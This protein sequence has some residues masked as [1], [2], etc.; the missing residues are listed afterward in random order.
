[1]AVCSEQ[2]NFRPKSKRLGL[3]GRCVD[4]LKWSK[5]ASCCLSYQQCE[6]TYQ[7]C[8]SRQT[9]DTVTQAVSNAIAQH[10]LLSRRAA[11]FAC[12][13]NQ[14]GQLETVTALQFGSL[15][16][17]AFYERQVVELCFQSNLNAVVMAFYVPYSS[18]D[19]PLEIVERLDRF[20][21]ALR[22]IEMCMPYVLWSTE[23]GMRV[24]KM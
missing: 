24:I 6:P 11:S 7:Q 14:R 16:D 3:K 1:M 12:F 10:S 20:A 15:N 22:L 2:L 21:R 17:I 5:Y 9:Y 19:C 18:P 4:C 23:G 8:Q 13:L